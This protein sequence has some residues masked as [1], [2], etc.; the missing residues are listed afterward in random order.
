VQEGAPQQVARRPAT[1]YV[2]RLMGLNLYSGRLRQDG[3]LCL[4]GG[5]DLVVVGAAST[6]SVLAVVRPSSITLHA[7]R[8]AGSPR[9]VWGGRVSGLE[10]LADRVRVQVD[11]TPP[12]L[13][14]VTADALA[15]L[16]IAEGAPVWLAAKATDIDV[17]PAP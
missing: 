6:G 4:D 13:V 8:P 2:A 1:Q 14:D 3:H 17:Y 16:G 11:G 12:A 5:G 10:L 15:E 7:D 9:N